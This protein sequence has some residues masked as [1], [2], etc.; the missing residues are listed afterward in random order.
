MLP[1]VLVLP[2]NAQFQLVDKSYNAWGTVFL[3]IR[4]QLSNDVLPALGGSK[5]AS[6]SSSSSHGLCAVHGMTSFQKM[7]VDFAIPPVLGVLMLL[8]F[9]VLHVSHIV[10]AITIRVSVIR[11]T[12]LKSHGD[13]QAATELPVNRGFVIKSPV[14]LQNIIGWGCATVPWSGRSPAL[15]ELEQTGSSASSISI[16]TPSGV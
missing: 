9:L 7:S 2:V 4:L 8:S 11:G 13:R 12:E 1:L 6:T 10:G 5:H 16:E 3:A 14:E 15:L